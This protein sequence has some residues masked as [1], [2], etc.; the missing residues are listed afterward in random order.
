MEFHYYIG[1]EKHEVYLSAILD[2]Y[3]RRIVTYV[4]C[5]NNNNT[6]VFDTVYKALRMNPDMHPLFHSDRGF[7]YTNRAFHNKLESAEI[8]QSVSRVSKCIVNG[9]MEGFW[10]I[11]KR[12]MLLRETIHR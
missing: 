11:L 3:D 5:D 2:L 7:Q 8:M 10:E 9:P 12:G 6:L 1:I 4:I